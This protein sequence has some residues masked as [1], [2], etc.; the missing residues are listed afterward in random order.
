MPSSAQA[1]T[2]H[3]Y[4]EKTRRSVEQDGPMPTLHLADRLLS[5]SAGD[6]R[7]VDRNADDAATLLNVARWSKDFLTRPH[8]ALGRAGHVCPYVHAAIREQRFL[9]TVLRDAGSQ[10][11][12]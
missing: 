4:D 6:L 10:Q 2:V 11:R 12:P 5:Y 1:Q 3:A 8:P 9:L 7:A